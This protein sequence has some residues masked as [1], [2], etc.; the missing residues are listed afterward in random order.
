[1]SVGHSV[2]PNDAEPLALAVLDPEMAH[3][4][5]SASARST[6]GRACWQKPHQLAP[7]LEDRDN[8]DRVE[9]GAR[10]FFDHARA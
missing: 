6:N 5:R 8:W 7:K 1:M 9:L 4:G 3:A 10:R 2:T